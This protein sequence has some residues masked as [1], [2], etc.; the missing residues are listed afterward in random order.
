[1]CELSNFF[2]S[3][4]FPLPLGLFVCVYQYVALADLQL[5]FCGPGQPGTQRSFCLCFLNAGI[6][7]M[8]HQAGLSLAH[9]KPWVSPD[10]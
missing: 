8:C 4:I 10:F 5:N 1:M 3:K 2:G 9:F 7:G 6:E